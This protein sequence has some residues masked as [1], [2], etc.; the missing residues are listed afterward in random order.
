MSIETLAY[1]GYKMPSLDQALGKVNSGLNLVR[2]KV[3]GLRE[4]S[5]DL[6]DR[7]IDSEID[8]HQKLSYPNVVGSERIIYRTAGLYYSLQEATVAAAINPNPVAKLWAK[9]AE[10]EFKAH[11]KHQPGAKRLLR[12]MMPH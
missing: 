11:L 5:L 1:P 2:E 7:I 12:Q 10:K 8:P 3:N 4:K 6:V 9:D